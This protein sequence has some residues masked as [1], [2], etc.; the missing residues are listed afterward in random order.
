MRFVQQVDLKVIDLQ[1]KQLSAVKGCL[2]WDQ[3]Y[4]GTFL[5]GARDRIR[6]VALRDRGLRVK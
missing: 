3:G 2:D 4:G 1:N 5:G 6:G